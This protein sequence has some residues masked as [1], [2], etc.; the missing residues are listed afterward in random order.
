MTFFNKLNANERLAAIG[1]AIVI[2]S[3]V[4]GAV[5]SYGIGSSVIALLGAIAVL[6][7][8][9]IKYSP[10]QSMTWPMPVQTIILGISGVSALLALLGALP[11]LG[12]LSFYG[13]LAIAAAIGTIVGAVIM[14]WGAWQ[15]YQ[16]MPKT[17][18]PSA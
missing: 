13:V 1:A 12:L 16:A 9:Y 6:V 11:L 3:W 10:T 18:P 4:V 2:I 5:G 17:T 7:I 15:D 14:A 8:Y